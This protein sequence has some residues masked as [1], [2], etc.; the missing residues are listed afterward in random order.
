VDIEKR[1]VTVQGGMR[2]H[3]LHQHLQEHHLAL[4]NLG[5]ISEQSIAGVISTATHGTGVKYGVL[6][7]L[8][9]IARLGMN[10]MY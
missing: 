9:G 6:S 3:R 10:H 4:S 5:S 8:V 2:L 1:R 7:S